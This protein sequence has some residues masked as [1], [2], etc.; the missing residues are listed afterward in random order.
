MAK[1]GGK[2]AGSRKSGSSTK[3]GRAAGMR[4]GKPGRRFIARRS[5]IHGRGVFATAKIRKGERV[6]E[7]VGE[8]ITHKEAD[9]RYADLHEYSPHTFLFLVNDRIV[10]DA[11]Y[12]GNTARWIN[13]SCQPNCEIEQEGERIFIDAVR[14]IRPGE[15]LTYDY[16]LVLEERHTPAAKKAHPCFCGSR[17]CRGTLLG[18]K[19]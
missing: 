3:K 17:R 12:G 1:S 6:I 4:R 14:D 13:H 15:E 11:T 5:G 16:N 8:R 9:K 2:K 10:I 7:Y 19:R 18:S